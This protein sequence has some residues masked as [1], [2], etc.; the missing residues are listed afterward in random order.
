MQSGSDLG[1]IVPLDPLRRTDSNS[2]F[3]AAASEGSLPPRKRP[4]NVVGLYLPQDESRAILQ[5]QQAIQAAIEPSGHT[6]V[7]RSVGCFE[8]AV[9]VAFFEAWRVIH[10]TDADDKVLPH[11]CDPTNLISPS[12]ELIFFCSCYSHATATE[13]IAAGLPF[14]IAASDDEVFIAGRA[15]P[16]GS[17]SVVARCREVE[18]GHMARGL[19]SDQY[20]QAFIPPFYAELARG[21]GVRQAFAGAAQATAHLAPK[22]GKFVLL[23]NPAASDSVYT[24]RPLGDSLGSHSL[25]S[26]PRPPST[27]P[28]AVPSIAPDPDPFSRSVVMVGMGLMRGPTGSFIMLGTGTF[29]RADGLVLTAWHVL[30][31]MLARPDALGLIATSSS[32]RDPV[33]LAYQAPNTSPA[34]SCSSSLLLLLLLYVGF[35]GAPH[36]IALHS[37]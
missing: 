11:L 19:V 9:D 17:K 14:A 23:H 3:L 15:P 35:G 29:I 33:Q 37:A 16:P 2:V 20:C 22:H 1:E 36:S 7:A 26:A 34:L 18:G 27:G 21:A 4:F 12:V 24:Y 13:C 30:R 10:V 32:W 5:E 8:E 6:F 28:A 25:R 31:E